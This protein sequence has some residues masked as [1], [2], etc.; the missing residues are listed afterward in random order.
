[1]ILSA[2][3]DYC[4]HAQEEICGGA[5]AVLGHRRHQEGC[6]CGGHGLNGDM[7]G[8]SDSGFPIPRVDM[9]ILDEAG[10][11]IG[12][13]E[14]I[15]LDV[16]DDCASLFVSTMD[17]CLSNEISLASTESEGGSCSVTLTTRCG[18]P[19]GYRRGGVIPRFRAVHTR[20]V[21]VE[22]EGRVN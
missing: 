3:E 17:G 7:C 21:R 22:H 13:G 10:T 8:Q 5:D 9:R 12:T 11:R 16:E 18:L 14:T 4:D 2:Y 19:R 20:Q 15:R 1:M 6:F